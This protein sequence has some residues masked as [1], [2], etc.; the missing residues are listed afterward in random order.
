MALSASD[1]A[2]IRR[3]LGSAE[4]G[5][6]DSDLQNYA[7]DAELE[8]PGNLNNAALAYVYR[9]LANDALYAVNFRQG[10][11]QE[12]D[13]VIYDRLM[14]R[15]NFWRGQ[16]ELPYQMPKVKMVAVR[17]RLIDVPEDFDEG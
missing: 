5:F 14:E 1:I 6:T 2:Y 8:D 17:L 4:A 3:Q 10:E 9:A 12:S 11:T 13:S 16:A 15:V 7:N